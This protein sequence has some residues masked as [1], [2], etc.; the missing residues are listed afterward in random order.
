[1]ILSGLT[2]HQFKKKTAV[3]IVFFHELFICRIY[4]SALKLEIAHLFIMTLVEA[5]CTEKVKLYNGGG[6]SLKF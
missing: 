4:S 6:L 3:K 5:L 1:M 2:L